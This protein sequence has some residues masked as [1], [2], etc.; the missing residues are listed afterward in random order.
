VYSVIRLVTS[1][2]EQI[3]P[4]VRLALLDLLSF[5]T[6]SV[7]VEPG[8]S[9][10][11][12]QTDVNL[13]TLHVRPAMGRAGQ[14]ACLAPKILLSKEIKLVFVMLDT[15]HLLP[16]LAR[17]ATT[18]ATLVSELQ[19]TNALLANSG[20][21]LQMAY[22]L[23]TRATTLTL[24]GTAESATHLVKHVQAQTRIIAQHVALD[25]HSQL[26][27]VLVQATHSIFKQIV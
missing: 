2:L 27:P 12:S 20:Q 23:A 5:L 26:I 16:A 11:R 4:N 17:L 10:I 13:V 15:S 21:V 25:Q 18:L 8:P 14:V 1:V 19:T 6:V 9:T 24:M 7:G 22:V 3:Q